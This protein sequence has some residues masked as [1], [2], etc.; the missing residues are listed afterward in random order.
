MIEYLTETIK[1]EKVQYV[2]DKCGIKSKRTERNSKYIP[3]G[4]VEVGLLRHYCP[5]CASKL[6]KKK[7]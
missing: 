6:N 5:L 4:W 2:C 7:Q 1:I 3:S